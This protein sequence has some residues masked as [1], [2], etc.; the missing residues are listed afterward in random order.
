MKKELLDFIRN[1]KKKAYASTNSK[2]I[3]TK[4]GGKNYK[5]KKGDYIYTD[6]YFGNL[7]D[8][9]QERVYYKGKVIWVMA[10]RGGMCKGFENLNKEAF[11]FLKKCIGKMPQDFP[12]RG[13]KKIISGKFR[14]ENKWHGDIDGFVG[15]ENIYF[16]QNQKICFRNYLGGLIRNKNGNT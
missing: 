16:N 13:P 4:D 12:V 3:R 10:Y 9:G 7:I 5:I 15:E 8:C 14:Y 6:T 1:S 11:D 2:P